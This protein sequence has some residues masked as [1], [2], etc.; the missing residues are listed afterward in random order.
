MSEE[1][2]FRDL[3]RRVR[4][5][6]QLA[7]TELV[8]QYE[9]EIRRAI[10]LRLTDPRLN[11]ILDSMDIC[12]SVMANFFV[13][14]HAGQFDL[15]RPDQLLRLLVTMARNRLLDQARRQQASRRD[16]R[17]VE[18]GGDER[19]ANVADAGLGTPSQI[20]SEREL[21]QAVR[22]Q[23]TDEER[24]LA[25]H[26]AQGKDWAEIAEAVGSTPEAVRKKLSRAMDRVTRR[27]GFDVEPGE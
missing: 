15:E 26:R 7:A 11:R 4:A 21:I 24:Q 16:G 18:A 3:I 23:M 9:P 8:R 12:Q 10:R 27:L 13:R 19:L 5:G 6:E 22:G 17:R 1:E 14:V 20:I 2:A 25:E